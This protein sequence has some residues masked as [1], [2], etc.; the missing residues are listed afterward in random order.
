MD[1]L[2]AMRVFV[3]VAEMRGFAPAARRLTMSPAAVTRAVSALEE[4]LGTRLL[5]RTTRVVRL[6]DAGARYLADCKRILGE[7]EEA[8]AGATGTEGEP[9]GM[10][11]VTA[12]VNFGRMFVAPIALG[13]LAKHPRTSV[14]MLLVDHVVHLIEEGIDVGVRIAH[15]RDSTLRAVRVG[16]V[17]RVVC[18][19][20]EYLAK[21]GTPRT[22][23]DLIQHDTIGFLNIHPTRHW[24]F[25]SGSKTETA[26]PETRLFVNTAD[27][28]IAAAKA[29]HGLTRAFSYQVE[30]DV[31]AGHLRV[32]L[33]DFEPAEVPIHIV[34]PDARRA[35]SSV[36]AF[37]DHAVER[38]RTVA[39]SGA[40]GTKFTKTR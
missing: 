30:P 37:V 22:P 35:T 25:A 11:N 39:Q 32:V 12:P 18:A 17:R 29:G 40:F 16:T 13:F 23:A 24:T 3:T 28:A 1:R 27:V 20:P 2:E 36:R 34:Y 10:L 21:R 5:R 15:L 14:R 6:T 33:E 9:R 4:R 26:E 31:R 19:A 8:E 38:L 7:I